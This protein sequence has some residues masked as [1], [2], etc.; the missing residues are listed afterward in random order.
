MKAT[1]KTA[2]KRSNDEKLLTYIGPQEKHG[3]VGSFVVDNYWESFNEV[4]R[5]AIGRFRKIAK[6]SIQSFIEA[7]KDVWDYVVEINRLDDIFLRQHSRRDKIFQSLSYNE[8][9]L[10]NKLLGL[11]LYS[12]LE[13]DCLMALNKSILGELA[14]DLNEKYGFT[15]EQFQLL[16]TPSFE[17]FFTKYHFDHLAYVIDKDPES[18]E[19]R[20]LS[21]INNFHAKDTAL[22]ELRF[23]DMC[24]SEDDNLEDTLTAHKEAL[25]KRS[26][27][28]H[29]FI[30]G[31]EE[32]IAFE[33]LLEYDNF[34]DF[35]YRYNLQACPEYYLRK[36]LFRACQEEG[37]FAEYSKPLALKDLEFIDGVND[38]IAL[39]AN[40]YLIQLEPEVDIY[41]IATSDSVTKRSMEG[42]AEEIFKCLKEGSPCLAYPLETAAE[43]A[44]DTILIV[45][46]DHDRL[47]AQSTLGRQLTL[48]APDLK[49]YGNFQIIERRATGELQ[50]LADAAQ[51]LIKRTPHLDRSG[52]ERSFSIPK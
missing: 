8:L 14:A 39:R 19:K 34:L 32:L 50:Q 10:A 1:N 21:L 40:R 36:L 31:R 35:E 25:A 45:G 49:Q 52:Y 7:Y 6:T 2:T 26:A 43:A 5:E 18:K 41:H 44:H 4:E 30:A 16:M 28:K 20:R 37:I 48:E 23:A 46:Y 42:S 29:D 17:T 15:D 33:K 22:F 13:K 24:F 3:L 12:E 47:I 38:L 27:K 51:R 11:S 9:K